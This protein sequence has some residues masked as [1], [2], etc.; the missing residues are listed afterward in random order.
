MRT[1]PQAKQA[2]VSVIVP[3]YN[4]EPY[5]RQCLESVA[6]QSHKALEV[7]LVDDGST[8]GSPSI[9]EEYA[10][11]YG[12]LLIR[13]ANQGLSAARQAG[14]NS[15][16]GLYVTFLDSDDLLAPDA[17]EVSLEALLAHDV[18][19]AAF[20]L[21]EFALDEEVKLEY[22]SA[23]KP[24]TPI[25]VKE[26]LRYHF[27]PDERPFYI[28]TM[29]A[30]GKLFKKTLL[31]GIDWELID[32]KSNE[33]E[34][35]ICYPYLRAE[36][37]MVL[38]DR[39]LY[40]YRKNEASKTRGVYLNAY[41]GV[42]LTR[43]QF[44]R[45]MFDVVSHIVGPGHRDYFVNYYVTMNIELYARDFIAVDNASSPVKD[46]DTLQLR[47]NLDEVIDDYL[48]LAPHITQPGIYRIAESYKK[49][50]FTGY[51][52][53][54]VQY[55]VKI[56]EDN[57]KLKDRE[58]AALYSSQSWRITKPLRSLLAVLRKSPK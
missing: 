48:A 10:A 11:L 16:A 47:S 40:F 42:P 24:H 32:F 7:V 35:F 19:I 43:M 57:I 9:A 56:R 34:L 20:R 39:A 1:T 13:Q 44:L 36:R 28:F 26:P 4:V 53:A 22:A 52:R 30:C 6:A 14:L 58:L 45:C 31:E 51:L 33:D 38:L 21:M 54:M 12:W 23:R 5:L 50:G 2:L 3:I 55:Q 37:G 25:M 41:R 18:D 17:I 29:T 15:S 27:T 46:S 8:D 49:D